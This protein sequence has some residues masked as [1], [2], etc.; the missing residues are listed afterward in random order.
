MKTSQQSLDV[1]SSPAMKPLNE[2]FCQLHLVCF[3]IGCDELDLTVKPH[4]QWERTCN[5]HTE[6]ISISCIILLSYSNHE[7]IRLLFFIQHDLKLA[8]RPQRYQESV[9]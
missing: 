6:P 4:A 2:C 5:S 1:K 7:H 8:I 3:E 9:Y